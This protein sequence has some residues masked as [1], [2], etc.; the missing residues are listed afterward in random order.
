MKPLLGL[1]LVL[2]LGEKLKQVRAA[3]SAQVAMLED[4][5]VAKLMRMQLILVAA[6]QMSMPVLEVVVLTINYNYIY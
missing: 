4:M 5:K 6:M 1:K 3:V 2:E